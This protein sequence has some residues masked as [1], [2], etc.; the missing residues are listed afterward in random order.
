VK[1]GAW[2]GPL[3]ATETYDS[4]SYALQNGISIFV[5]KVEYHE[6]VHKGK[7]GGE[8]GEE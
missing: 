1:G 7:G 2:K 5:K 6:M 4:S 3:Q 8:V